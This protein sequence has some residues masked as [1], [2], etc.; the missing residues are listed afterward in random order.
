MLYT[1]CY[2]EV[3]SLH[4]GTWAWIFRRSVKNILER[5]T[6]TM[7]SQGRLCDPLSLRSEP[8]RL[9]DKHRN[10]SWLDE[11][12][13]VAA[14]DEVAIADPLKDMRLSNAELDNQLTRGDGVWRYLM[15]D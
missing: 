14:K 11:N 12:D 9:L 13:K 1:L 4:I 10:S 5:L 2:A 7:T 6:Y 3:F 15:N 8:R